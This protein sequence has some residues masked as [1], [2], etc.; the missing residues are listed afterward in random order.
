[1]VNEAVGVKPCSS[2]EHASGEEGLAWR[3]GALPGVPAA[4]G[5][6]GVCL[7]VGDFGQAV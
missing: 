5:A 6:P 2:R 1:M 3:L 7:S 4:P